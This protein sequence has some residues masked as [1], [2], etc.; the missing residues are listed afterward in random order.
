MSG[1]SYD[2]ASAPNGT[3]RVSVPCSTS[4]LGPGFD[5][6][7]LCL[8]L[9]LDARV[10]PRTAGR[11]AVEATAP[12]AWPSAGGDL[13]WR[14]FE[15]AAGPAASGARIE[16]SS[17]IPIGRGLGS[18]G[19]AVAAGL[20]LGRAWSG[21]PAP[22]RRALLATGV[23]LEGHP[24]NV[25]ASLFGGCTLCVPVDE[26][27][28][29]LIQVDV[30]PDLGFAAAWPE[31]PL[32]TA[33]ARAALPDRVPFA[34]AVENAR[35]LP[36][37]LEGLRRADPQLLRLGSDDR[38]HQRHR[39]PLIPGAAEALEAARDSGA[40]AAAISGAGSAVV[41]LTPLDR[42]EPVARAMA[43]ALRTATGSAT[44]RA[45]D[46]VRDAPRVEAL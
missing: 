3:Y 5:Q 23:E 36:L 37:L 33:R 44:A 2:R 38:L 30:H 16:V 31:A 11:P 35:R 8:S 26:L 42:R 40:H 18:T 32:E 4:N 24:D 17:A 12:D 9:F 46:V 6:L 19:A 13:L 25:A 15:R 34:D 1:D 28:L 10:S 22:D 14:A 21:D 20:L 39:L 41:A 43:A 7:G 27:P 29:P 45:L